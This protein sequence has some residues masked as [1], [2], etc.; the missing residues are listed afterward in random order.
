M[1][2]VDMIDVPA[3]DNPQAVGD[4]F[5]ACVA[6]IFEVK[7]GL[8]PHFMAIDKKARFYWTYSL[9]QWLAPQGLWYCDWPLE[10]KVWNVFVPMDG[11]YAVGTGESPRYPGEHHSVVVRLDRHKGLTIM[12]DPHPSRAGVVGDKIEYIGMFMSRRFTCR[13][14]K[15]E[16]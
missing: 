7:V 13:G 16:D 4:C 14:D 1:K 2:P 12:H 3:P 15:D 6:S 9:D 10:P 11:I 8:V 5:R